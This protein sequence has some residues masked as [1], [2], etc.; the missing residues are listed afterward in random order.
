MSRQPLGKRVKFLTSEGNSA[1]L[2]ASARD[3][4]DRDKKWHDYDATDVYLKLTLPT[5]HRFAL[6]KG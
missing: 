4:K 5:I 6:T 2:P 3:K 1:L